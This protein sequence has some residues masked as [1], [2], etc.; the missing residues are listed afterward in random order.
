[1]N[2]TASV[3]STCRSLAIGQA[4]GERCFNISI[5]SWMTLPLLQPWSDLAVILRVKPGRVA[6]M[7]FLQPASIRTIRL[8]QRRQAKLLFN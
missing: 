6:A 3:I 7:S 4:G 1:M 5:R 2:I 8:Q